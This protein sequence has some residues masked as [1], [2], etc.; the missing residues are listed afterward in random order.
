MEL[1]KAARDAGFRLAFHDVVASTNDLAMAALLKGEDRHWF[2]AGQQQAGRGRHG[3]DW[4]SPPGNLYA[5]LALA[6]PCPPAKAPLMGFVAGLSLIEALGHVAPA[7]Q[8]VL[9]LKWPND[10]QIS[11]EKVAGILLEG[12][13][14]A[15]GRTGI[16]IGMGANLLRRP[17]LSDYAV[18][19]LAEHASGVSVEALFVALS[20]RFAANLALFDRGAGFSAIRSGW[21]RHALPLGTKLRVRLPAGEKHGTFGGLDPEGH[22]L[23]DTGRAVEAVMVG[24]VFLAEGLI[25]PQTAMRTL[26]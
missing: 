23:L 19:A 3:R 17:D 4:I 6:T 15:E 21:L 1:G 2:V 9:H 18:T 8:P 25:D 10:C 5:S 24:D 22:L 14:L 11:G 12:T 13:S 26:G 20:D 7:L 16:V